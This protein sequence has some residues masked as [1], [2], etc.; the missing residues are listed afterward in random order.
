MTP[1]EIYSLNI[2]KKMKVTSK[3]EKNYTAI[4]WIKICRDYIRSWCSD[5]KHGKEFNERSRNRECA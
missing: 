5:R 4:I 2:I 3:N 1:G